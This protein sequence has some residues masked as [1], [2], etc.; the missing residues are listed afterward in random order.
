M[1]VSIALL[2]LCCLSLTDG[3]TNVQEENN[4]P[5][6]WEEVRDIRDMMVELR[7]KLKMAMNDKSK[8]AEQILDLKKE[9]A[10]LNEHLKV[11][12]TQLE[13]LKKE[14]SEQPKVA[15][16]AD[17]GIRG[18]IGPTTTEI[19]L[20]FNNVFT[21]IGNNY[22]S[23]TGFFT[24]PVKGVYYFRFTICGVQKN[25]SR[26]AN[27]YK[28]GQNIVSVG[29]EVY[30]DQHRYASNGAVLQLEVGD[31]ICMKLLPGYTIYDSPGN[32]S[33]FSG[34]LIYPL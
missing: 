14:I 23:I 4:L 12:E 20:A 11:S 28:N 16:S 2:M 29:Q 26:G 10:G 21:N 22:N 1:K 15:F 9:N 3:Q 13:A 30:H 25:Q 34:F 7:V 18:N 17:L 6:I 24:A 33:T 31:V 8:M 27:L 19:T 5:N 32:L